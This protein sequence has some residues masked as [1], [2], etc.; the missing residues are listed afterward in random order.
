MLQ[1]CEGCEKL[2]PF[3]S[4]LLV[5]CLEEVTDRS[6]PPDVFLYKG[7]PKISSKFASDH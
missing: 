6:S 4:Y 7:V 3:A 5:G 1:S 2:L